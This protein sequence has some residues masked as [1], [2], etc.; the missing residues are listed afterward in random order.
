MP[1]TCTLAELRQ[2]WEGI[3]VVGFDTFFSNSFVIGIFCVVANAVFCSLTRT[4]SRGLQ[5]PEKIS[6]SPSCCLP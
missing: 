4:P 5:I 1:H 2:R 3:G 6:G